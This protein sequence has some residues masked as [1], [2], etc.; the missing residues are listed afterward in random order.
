MYRYYILQIIEED[1]GSDCY[2]FQKWGQFGNN[3]SVKTCQ[4]KLSKSAAIREFKQLFIQKTGKSWEAWE[5][6][7]V[8]FQAQPGR[9][10][11]LEC[12]GI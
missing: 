12:Q 8:Q 11:P 6:R 9:Y 7:T 1:E 3:K 4:K 5:Q 2:L 10:F